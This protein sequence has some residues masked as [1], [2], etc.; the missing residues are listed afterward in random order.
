MSAGP[1]GVRRAA[2][3]KALAAG[4]AV[5][6]VTCIGLFL[7]LQWATGRLA[8]ARALA[9][10]RQLGEVNAR[11]VFAPFVTD[12][13]LAAD[14]DALT[15]L[16]ATAHRYLQVSGALRVKVWDE[17]QRIVFSDE[18]RLIGKVFAFDED[19]LEALREGRTVAAVSDLSKPENVFERS[20]RR[21]LEVYVRSTTP[22]GKLVLIETYYPYDLVTATASSIEDHLDPIAL[23]GL[24]LLACIQLPAW[25]WLTARLLRGRQQRTMLVERLMNVSDTER[26]RVAGEVH[27]GAV[28]E[29]IGLSYAIGGIAE[30]SPDAESQR[31]HELSNDLTGVIHQLRTL[32]TSIYPTPR[33]N[34]D[35]GSAI[36][37]MLQGLRTAGVTVSVEIDPAIRPQPPDEV[38]LLRTVRELT[39]NIEAHSGATNVLVRLSG[40]RGRVV[41]DVTDD[42][43]GFE[44]SE[45]SKRPSAG[46]FGLQL[47]RDLAHDSGGSLSITTAPGQGTRA[48]L[49]LQGEP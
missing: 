8:T 32:L 26:R 43:V 5:T 34:G 39:R 36:E 40:N 47:L 49:E 48:H 25:T 4:L 2:L 22:A 7:A 18:P 11:A 27:D 37:P 13:A 29:L 46:H 14:E 45:A 1:S 24:G 17:Q 41:L 21:L 15:A 6:G 44:L 30:R 16:D 42:G 31:L 19:D 33:S 20:N 10:A 23:V 35:L 28:Q 12:A 9:D 3:P 38:V